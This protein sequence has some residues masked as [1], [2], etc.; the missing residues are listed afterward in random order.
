M[1]LSVIIPACNEEKYIVKT[2]ESISYPH[3][4][5]IVVCNGCTDKTF[6]VVSEYGKKSGKNIH[7]FNLPDR[8][9]SKARN[10]GAKMAKGRK[11]IFLDADIV[12]GK[13][14]LEKIGKAKCDVGTTFVKADSKKALPNM[15]MFLKNP[16][17]YFGYCAGLMFCTREIFDKVGGFEEGLNVGEDGKF[18][19][20]IRKHGKYG[21]IG[22]FVYNNMRRFEKIGYW[23]VCWFWIREFFNPEAK[24]YEI[25]R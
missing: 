15:L 3:A 22:A 6:D 24:E 8:G 2:L 16:T 12:L 23:K 20:A 13:D 25:V 10:F 11:L 1:D 7:I 18:L 17:H 19:R 9:V 5:V 4:E 14:V 21:V